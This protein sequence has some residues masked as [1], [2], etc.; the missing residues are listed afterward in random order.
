MTCSSRQVEHI[1][2]RPLKAWLKTNTEIRGLQPLLLPLLPVR[3]CDMCVHKLR[4]VRDLGRGEV[5]R[6]GLHKGS[7]GVL[8]TRA[9]VGMS[10]GVHG[11]FSK[12][13][14]N[15][16]CVQTTCWVQGMV[17]VSDKRPMLDKK[18][19][20]MS[21]TGRWWDALRSQALGRAHVGF[22]APPAESLPHMTLL[23]P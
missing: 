8:Y 23:C 2:F 18:P 15:P 3:T 5:W 7:R 13:V 22:P 16:S 21:I 20:V 9:Q 4:L 12:Y 17:R 11:S 19:P 10:L 14:L 1:L 6:C